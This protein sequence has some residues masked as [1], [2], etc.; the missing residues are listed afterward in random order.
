MAT[1]ESIPE[2]LIPTDASPTADSLAEEIVTASRE[3]IS[4]ERMARGT[5]PPDSTSGDIINRVLRAL[6]V[7]V[8]GGDTR[9]EA[10]SLSLG[11]SARTLQRTLG[12]ERTTYRAVLAH[13][14]RHRRDQLR[15]LGLRDGEIAQRLGFYDL[16]AMRR[17]LDG[18]H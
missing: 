12:A 14:R 9:V 5:M 7:T 3:I 4:R 15:N 16:R 17:S 1:A 10:T 13:A 11:V 18:G 6:E 8:E 2:H